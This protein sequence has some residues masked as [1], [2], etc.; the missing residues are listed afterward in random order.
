MW[1]GNTTIKQEIVWKNRGL[2]FKEEWR[3]KALRTC[4]TSFEPRMWRVFRDDSGVKP[5][6]SVLANYNFS[7]KDEVCLPKQD[8]RTQ[9]AREERETD[10]R[11]TG[12]TR[13]S[14]V[15]EKKKKEKRSAWCWCER[16]DAPL[17]GCLSVCLYTH[18]HTHTQTHTHA[19]THAHARTD[20]V[21]PSLYVGC[22]QRVGAARSLKPVGLNASAA[23]T[24]N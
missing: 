17:A 20:Y 11:S 16:G 4:S 3:E 21:V 15:M 7:K 6:L 12:W 24:A 1:S 23:R 2:C 22:P 19:R 8:R 13:A 10:R 5:V 9:T 14:S 18:T